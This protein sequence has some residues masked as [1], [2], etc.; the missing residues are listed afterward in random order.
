MEVLAFR[1]VK[2]VE[3]GTDVYVFKLGSSCDGT[4]LAA[5]T[6]NHALCVFDPATLLT[7][8]RLEGHKDIVQ[9][10]EFF[11][12]EPSC[13]ASCSYDGTAR[14]WDVRLADACAR[15][16]KV[17]KDEIYSCSVGRSDTALACAAAEKVHLFD[18]GTGKRLCVYHAIHTDTVNHVRFHP[19][20]TTRLL[21]GAED[22]LLCVLDTNATNVDDALIACIPNEECVRSFTI[23]GPNRDNLCCA[24]T[25]EEVRIWSLGDDLGVKRAE[26][27][28]L[29]EH[30][31]LRREESGGY[32]VETFYDQPSGQVYVLAGAG[33]D[34]DLALF[35][36]TTDFGI[37]L[38]AVFSVPQEGDS[39]GH[40]G[41]VRSGL[42][43][44]GGTLVTAGED[45]CVVA[46][47]EGL[48]PPSTNDFGREGDA[49][50]AT[51]PQAEEGVP[52]LPSSST[53]F[54]LEPTSYGASRG[55]GIS[56]RPRDLPY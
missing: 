3:V 46:W 19:V 22:N 37:L 14:V 43:L 31:L 47:R 53:H 50:K 2:H 34:G 51:A 16:F 29:R 27:L 52:H 44:P 9:D 26:F 18:V 45:G 28:G 1:P 15:S 54:D 42:C 17:T 49:R 38:A 4:S 48:A 20:D 36:A 41:V 6:S 21:T 23:V 10:L 35:R 13:L 30:E 12:F 55:S 5:A 25:T 7:V 39:R 56:G 11:Q 32:V 33:A 24:S 40:I 8:R